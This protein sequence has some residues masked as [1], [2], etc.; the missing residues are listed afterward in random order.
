MSNVTPNNKTVCFYTIPA[1]GH[2]NAM[3]GFMEKLNKEG[4]KVIAY[5]AFLLKK[6]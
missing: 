6:R 3:W 2:V 5:S 4:F 1:T